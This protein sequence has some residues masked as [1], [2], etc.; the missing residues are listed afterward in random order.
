M[1]PEWLWSLIVFAA[2]TTF[3][4]GPNNVM[5]TA[6]GANFGYR[7]SVPHMLGI[8][9]GFPAMVVGVG[10]GLA[11]VFQ[12]V[13]WLHAALK[14][15][16]AAYLLWLAWRIARSGRAEAKARAR[17]LTFLEAAGFQW[18]N[19]KAWMM[20]TGALATFTT[21][22]GDL[23]AEVLVIA[24][25]FGLVCYPSVSI[26]TACGVAIGRL[27][28]TDRALRAFNWTMAGLLVLSLA[29]VLLT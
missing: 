25:V 4:P 7:R 1:T 28:A 11:G 20:A 14:Y 15:A 24:L 6:S 3:T 17:P 22:G 19:G 12:A 9:L 16:G 21:L 26:W 2:V 10:L 5:V 23:V 27:L 29:P 13:P 18:V 8:T